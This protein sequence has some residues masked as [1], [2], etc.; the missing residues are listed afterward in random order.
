MILYRI[1]REKRRHQSLSGEGAE[2]YGGRWNFPGHRAV[3][4][5]GSRS[6]AILEMLVHID[7]KYQMPED[8]IL[9]SIEIAAEVRIKSKEI[10]DLENGW[11][12]FLYNEHSQKVFGDF[13]RENQAAVLSVPSVIVPEEYNFILNPLHPD[14]S[15]IQVTNIR[16]LNLDPRIVA[17]RP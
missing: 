12:D 13:V 3:Y 14:F 9:L 16:A 2:L 6:L 11:N 15:K 1:D 10:F 8:R 17:F 4:C 7:L 5:A